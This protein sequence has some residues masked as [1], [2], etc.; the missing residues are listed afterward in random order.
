MGNGFLER[1]WDIIAI[2]ESTTTNDD[3]TFT[4]YQRETYVETNGISYTGQTKTSYITYPLAHSLNI[5][6]TKIVSFEFTSQNYTKTC[7]HM[8]K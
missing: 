1:V 3:L 7:Y 4:E 2:T 5:L 6:F 8:K